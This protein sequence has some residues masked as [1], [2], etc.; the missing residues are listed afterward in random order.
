MP[1][2][3]QQHIAIPLWAKQGVFPEAFEETLLK[4]FYGQNPVASG[5]DGYVSRNSLGK[6]F[7][8]LL[9]TYITMQSVISD[10]LK[11]LWQ[12]GCTMRAMNWMAGRVRCSI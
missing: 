12:D 6:A 8:D 1:D 10:S 2:Q 9:V 11:A 7:S 4:R 5:I 3:L